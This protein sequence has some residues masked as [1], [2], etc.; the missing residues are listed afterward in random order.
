MLSLEQLQPKAAVRGIIPD[1]DVE[2]MEVEL[3]DQA[4]AARSITKLD[5]E[6]T[7]LRRLEALAAEVARSGADT[8]WRQLAGLLGKNLHP[9][10]ALLERPRAPQALR[11][12]QDRAA[13]AVA[14]AEARHLH[15]ASRHTRVP[16][17]QH[18]PSP[19]SHQ[20][21]TLQPLARSHASSNVAPLVRQAELLHAAAATERVRVARMIVSPALTLLR[22][23]S[24]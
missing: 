23:G 20:P 17:A 21:E 4:A 16:R 24:R 22:S 11:R 18:Q 9:Q 12:R 6:L 15:R 8:K 7:T 2:S 10:R 14:A 5:A 13:E 19:R 1:A 3:I